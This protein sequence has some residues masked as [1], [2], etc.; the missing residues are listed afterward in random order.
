MRIERFVS[1][2]ILTDGGTLACRVVLDDGA[3]VGLGLD[4]R[5]PRSEAE[6][7]VFIG[8]DDPASSDARFLARGSVEEREVVAAIEDYLDRSCGFL[9]REMLAEADPSGLSGKDSEDW[10]AVNLMRAILGR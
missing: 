7:L 2:M 9:R 6:R 8:S 5:V 10:L 1:G 4:A 3:E